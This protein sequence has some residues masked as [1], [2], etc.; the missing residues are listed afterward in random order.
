MW[1]VKKNSTFL[2]TGHRIL[3]SLSCKARELMVAKQEIVL[4][5]TGTV[6][7]FANEAHFFRFRVFFRACSLKNEVGDPPCFFLHF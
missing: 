5:L 3:L 7:L 1:K 6:A 4:G 2:F